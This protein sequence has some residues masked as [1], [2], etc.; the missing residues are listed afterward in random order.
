MLHSIPPDAR[1]VYHQSLSV[2]HVFER[3]AVMRCRGLARD[4]HRGFFFA[5]SGDPIPAI[6]K[7][8]L[9]DLVPR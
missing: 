2:V 3:L 8:E 9:L 6:G 7:L 4:L 1:K 5:V